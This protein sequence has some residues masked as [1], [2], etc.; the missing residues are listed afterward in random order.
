MRA[1]E[2]VEAKLKAIQDEM[3][4]NMRQSEEGHRLEMGQLKDSIHEKEAKL[5]QVRRELD[6]ATASGGRGELGSAVG[7]VFKLE[8]EVGRLNTELFEMKDELEA[9]T[10][11]RD[12]LKKGIEEAEGEGAEEE[13][14]GG[15]GGGGSSTVMIMLK[16]QLKR[17][18]NEN[19]SL[20][21]Y[22][23]DVDDLRIERDEMGLNA[24][25]LSKS[26]RGLQE[27]VDE[28]QLQLIQKSVQLPD[29]AKQNRLRKEREEAQRMDSETIRVLQEETDA[30]KQLLMT[31]YCSS[32]DYINSAEEHLVKDAIDIDPIEMELE[33]SLKNLASAIDVGNGVTIVEMS[34]FSELPH[35]RKLILEYLDD[36]FR[37]TVGVTREEFMSLR[38]VRDNPPKSS[39]GGGMKVDFMAKQREFKLNKKLGDAEKKIV[40]IKEE[41]KVVKDGLVEQ[42]GEVTERAEKTDRELRRSL[43]LNEQYVPQVKALEKI[44]VEYEDLQV[45]HNTKMAEFEECSGELLHKQDE[46]KHFS[47]DLFKCNIKIKNYSRDMEE[48][49]N[50]LGKRTIE[51]KTLKRELEK[52]RKEIQEI[53]E[54]EQERLDT[55]EDMGTQFSPIQ[56]EMG[57]Q[58]DFV[59]R[60]VSLRQTNSMTGFPGKMWAKP[61]VSIIAKGRGEGGGA[62]G[63]RREGWG[64]FGG[65]QIGTGSLLP[66]LGGGGGPETHSIEVMT[67]FGGSRQLRSVGGG[68]GGGKEVV[69]GGKQGASRGQAGGEQRANEASQGQC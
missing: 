29:L 42:L 52:E 15:G 16:A 63:E 31:V 49:Q 39:G 13:K 40:Q 44:R 35:D 30:V 23:E 4:G 34:A 46:I 48:A 59:G 26:N 61:Y 7:E 54:A 58:T 36:R 64:T 66:S 51:V 25:Q 12:A 65:T 21:K 69:G 1:K 24:K 60:E 27:K 57:C 45:K 17:I 18:K 38:D 28:M 43:Q 10:E 62:G 41:S 3:E 47:A 37:N 2:E 20:L 68:K 33:G 32:V 9:V 8:A 56:V 5:L 50:K 14:E 11:E 19:A 53:K 55:N 22:K 6:A 67:S